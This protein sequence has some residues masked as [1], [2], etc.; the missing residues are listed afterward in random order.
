MD[1]GIV[2]WGARMIIRKSLQKEVLQQLHVSHQG[3]E[4]MLGRARQIAYWPNS[5]DDIRNTVR[6]C[7]ACAERLPSQPPEPLQRNEQLSRPFESV[8]GDLFHAGA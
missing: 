2:L 5:S 1:N 7:A 6:T 8:A 4:R 3:Q